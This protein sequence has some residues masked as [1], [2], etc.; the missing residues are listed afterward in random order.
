MSIFMP[1][2]NWIDTLTAWKDAAAEYI[3]SSITGEIPISKQQE[4]I[5]A[6]AAD[7]R[8]AGATE[9]QVRDATGQLAAFMTQ[10]NVE[11]RE[12]STVPTSA[13]FGKFGKYA[14]AAIVALAVFEVARLVRG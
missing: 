4:L 2:P 7:M 6:L 11:N 3:R 13:E 8:K 14:V 10:L 12:K 1:L 5:M 9:E